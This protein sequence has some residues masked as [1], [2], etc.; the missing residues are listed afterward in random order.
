MKLVV[1]VAFNVITDEPKSLRIDPMDVLR[2]DHAAVLAAIHRCEVVA[3]AALLE[4][5]A[6]DANLHPLRLSR[7]RTLVP[8]PEQR[9]TL[10]AV[11]LLVSRHLTAVGVE[12]R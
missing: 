10:F 3:Q 5:G 6:I 7:L 4:A 8:C 12:V 2:R 1:L 9:A 11:Q